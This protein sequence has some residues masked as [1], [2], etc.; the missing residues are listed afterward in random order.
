VR[1]FRIDGAAERA[2]CGAG[3]LRRA[4]W[5]AFAAAVVAH[6][7]S[8]PN[9]FVFDD[10]QAILGNPV[11]KGA[12]SVAA[13]FR[14]DFWG[15]AGTVGTYRPLPVL[16][17]WIDWR[18]GGGTAWPFHIG[19]VLAHGLVAA[20]LAV[21]LHRQAKAAWAAVIFGVLAVNTEAVASAVGRADL[22]AT[23][24]C[25]AAW[26][27]LDTPAAS[28]PKTRAAVAAV[29]LFAAL[30]C[31][32]AAVAFVPVLF[33]VDGILHPGPRRW[34]RYLLPATAILAYVGVRLA[35][36]GTH[37]AAVSTFNNPLLGTSLP[38]RLWTSLDLLSRAV[39][40]ELLPF[41]LSPDYGAAEIL[42]AGVGSTGAWLGLAILVTLVAGAILVRKKAPLFSAGA[43]LFLIAFGVVSNGF[44]VL[45]TIF[46]ERLLYF[47]SLGAAM[48]L[49][50]G[51]AA[52]QARHRELAFIVAAPLLVFQL[53]M[54]VIHDRAWSSPLSLFSVAVEVSPHSARAWTN[55][56]SALSHVGRTQDAAAAA[57]RSTELTPG[58]AR[59][60]ALLGGFLDELGHF[61]TAR[62]EFQTSYQLEPNDP[63]VVRNVAIFFARH[64][65]RADA[66]K[67]V[68][69]FV[70]THPSSELRNLLQ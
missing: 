69:T 68:D 16:S 5:A 46:A 10:A 62:A 64:G 24:G 50:S 28:R 61:E 56:A 9:G 49:G 70:K 35:C 45:P 12:F 4:A 13:F 29:L 43:A 37:P 14:T 27:V 34:A 32:E 23:L 25:V 52:L 36:F 1:V 60:H 51:L 8:L 59:P 67:I 42:P 11:V 18:L 41:N 38:T 3:S 19:N 55:Y 53:T 22:W 44:V 54:G 58:W 31:K 17:F 57:R 21:A 7:A 26:A 6:L 33:V 15:T 47:P 66:Q 40:L 2:V 39:R 48:M 63:D 20:L 65:G 30:L